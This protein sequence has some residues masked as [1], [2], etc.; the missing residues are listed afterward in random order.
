MRTHKQEL[1]VLPA[2]KR[3]YIRTLCHDIAQR[4]GTYGMMTA[5][6]FTIACGFTPNK[7]IPLQKAKQIIEQGGTLQDRVLPIDSIFQ[8]KPVLDR[9]ASPNHTF[10]Q[11]GRD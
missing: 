4:W 8:D 7:T 5:L 11:W 2:P 1:C 10:L 6:R 9:F 3:T